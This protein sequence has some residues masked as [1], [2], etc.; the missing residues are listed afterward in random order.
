MASFGHA[1]VCFR[2]G[3]AYENRPGQFE[4]AEAVESALADRKPLIVE[5]G[6]GKARAYLVPTIL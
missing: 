1:T 4:M 6:T 2:S 5:V 3:I